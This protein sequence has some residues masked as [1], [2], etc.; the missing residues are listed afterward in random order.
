LPDPLAGTPLTHPKIREPPI[1]PEVVVKRTILLDKE[2][3]VVNIRQLRAGGGSR[4]QKH[5]PTSRQKAGRAGG[6][7]DFEESR[8]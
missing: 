3:D 6:R 7:T 1:A 2:D 5:S 8:R 4:G